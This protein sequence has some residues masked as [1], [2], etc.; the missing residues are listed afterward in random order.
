MCVV[1]CNGVDYSWIAFKEHVKDA[2]RGYIPP[3]SQ[4]NQPH[5]M[6]GFTFMMMI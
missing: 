3:L 2:H 1:G 4:I 6:F 5:G